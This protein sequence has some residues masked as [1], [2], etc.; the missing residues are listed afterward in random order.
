MEYQSKLI[1][2]IGKR[3]RLK[4][5][6]TTRH[7]PGVGIL[8]IAQKSRISIYPP[9]VNCGRGRLTGE[10]AGS[11]S[12]EITSH[13]GGGGDEIYHQIDALPYPRVKTRSP[14][15]N[16]QLALREIVST[17]P[18]FFPNPDFDVSENLTVNLGVYSV[19]CWTQY[20]LTVRQL[21]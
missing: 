20:L 21:Q 19:N 1:K 10:W 12:I 18:Y 6:V 13:W 9:L 3:S 4:T 11:S 2:S 15:Q 16:P 8:F 7:R 5:V 14:L 17:P